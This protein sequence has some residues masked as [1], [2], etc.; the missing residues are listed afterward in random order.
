M[1]EAEA[2]V[3]AEEGLMQLQIGPL[4]READRIMICRTSSVAWMENRIPP[5][6]IWTPISIMDGQT[7]RKDSPSTANELRTTPLRLPHDAG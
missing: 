5:T 1:F 6:T 2:E 4:P 7:R 3:V